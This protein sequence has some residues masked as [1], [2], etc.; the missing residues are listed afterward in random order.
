MQH[1]F[2]L[3]YRDT[4]T[5][6][7]RLAAAG[8]YTTGGAIM[9]PVSGRE[10]YIANVEGSGNAVSNFRFYLRT[11]EQLPPEDRVRIQKVV[12]QYAP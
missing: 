5:L 3:S 1:S 2:C 6:L 7:L 4:N 12:D 10:E 11:F 8:C 9:Y